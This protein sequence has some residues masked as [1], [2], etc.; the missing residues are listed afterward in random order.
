MR[1]N[2]YKETRMMKGNRILAALA[3]VALVSSCGKDEINQ[4]ATPLTYPNLTQISVVTSQP[5]M[6]AIAARNSNAAKLSVHSNVYRTANPNDNIHHPILG[7]IC[8][9]AV[10]STIRRRT[11]WHS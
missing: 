2:L 4:P 11:S 8:V 9:V 5:V 7:A 6:N 3:L 1:P 10:L